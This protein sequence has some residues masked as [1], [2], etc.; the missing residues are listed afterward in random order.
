MR[1]SSATPGSVLERSADRV[2]ADTCTAV[3]TAVSFTAAK[4][5]SSLGPSSEDRR[6]EWGPPTRWTPWLCRALGRAR[7]SATPWTAAR[8]APRSTKFSRQEYWSGLPFPSPGDL[9]NPR[10]EPGSLASQADS[11]PSEPPGKSDG[12]FSSVQFSSVS[13]SC[14]TL[15]D[16]MNCSMP[17]FPVLHY[18]PEF[19]QIHV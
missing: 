13:Q 11:L 5:G 1:P 15:C 6:T 18:L 2:S 14:L 19:A 7:L 4:G 8:Q 3:R 12:T 9:F 17:V 10:I 16:P